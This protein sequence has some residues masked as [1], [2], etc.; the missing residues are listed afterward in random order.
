MS[1]HSGSS[2][3]EYVQK[4]KNT[5]QK[6]VSVEDGRNGV[7]LPAADSAVMF[8][9]GLEDMFPCQVVLEISL[10]GF[11]PGLRLL[12][13]CVLLAGLSFGV[14]CGLMVE[15]ESTPGLEFSVEFA[16]VVVV[17]AATVAAAAAGIVS[18]T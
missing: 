15:D 13:R 17:V 2:L 14:A 5:A 12:P 10:E 1:R 8:M 6:R 3:P 18:I 4:S 16:V 7:L 9:Q 11:V